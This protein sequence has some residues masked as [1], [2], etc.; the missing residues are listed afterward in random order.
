MSE[1]IFPEWVALESRTE[2]LRVWAMRDN[3]ILARR[4][5]EV[6][7]ERPIGFTLEHILKSL[8]DPWRIDPETPV[9]GCGIMKPGQANAMLTYRRVPCTPLGPELIDVPLRERALV[10]IP[11]LRQAE[12]CDVMYGEE[13]RIAG[14]LAAN[15][16]WD[17][18]LCLPG[19]HTRWVQVSAGEVV[20][21]QTYMTG[22]IY[23]L[24][25]ER[26]VLMQSIV[27][28]DWSDAAFD[29]ALQ[30]LLSNPEKLAARLFSIH[31]ADML[32]N[33]PKGTARSKLSAALIGAELAAARP[34]W[35]GTQIAIIGTEEQAQI[36][37]R[38]LRAQGAQATLAQK[39]LMTLAG[40]STVYNGLKG[41]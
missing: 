19:A 14:F 35:L 40:L 8:L 9:I 27:G 10:W 32:E 11:G 2:R 26:S 23:A 15:T 4:E 41:R 13:T 6:A 31:A 25:T 24:L 34:Y 17:G 39:E 30:D 12:P 16:D 20:S 37:Q 28:A 3:Q 33:A 38:A 7:P 18:V 1:Q 5:T 36:Y 29:E 22:E 21:F